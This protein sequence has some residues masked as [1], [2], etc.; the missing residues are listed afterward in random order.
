LT[1]I[2]FTKTTPGLNF[3]LQTPDLPDFGLPLFLQATT[4]NVHHIVVM[5]HIY[6]PK[7]ALFSAFGEWHA[8]Q[9]GYLACE[10]SKKKQTFLTRRRSSVLAISQLWPASPSLQLS[11]KLVLQPSLK[12]LM[13][14]C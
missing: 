9:L 1:S 8:A 11:S 10:F 2:P 3:D 5:A 4:D 13:S 6:S 14:T 7:A 12:I